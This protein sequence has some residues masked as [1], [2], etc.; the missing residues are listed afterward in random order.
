MAS[1]FSDDAYCLG[2]IYAYVYGKKR[3]VLYTDLI[4]F[5]AAIEKNLEGASVLDMYVTMR[6][7]DP[8]IYYTSEGKN[9]ELYYVLYPD[10]DLERAMNKY[11]GSLSSKTIGA[12]Q[13]NNALNCIGLEKVNKRIQ[14]KS[15][16]EVKRKKKKNKRY[17][18][19][20]ILI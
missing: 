6:S 17:M 2:L 8:S 4:D 3:M 9:G 15:K 5:H 7:D 19:E 10:F 1:V 20:N 18:K 16:D 14:P 12:S 11:I 13:K